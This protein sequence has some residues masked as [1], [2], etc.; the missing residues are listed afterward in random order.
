[1]IAICDKEQLGGIETIEDIGFG[2]VRPSIKIIHASIDT[3]FK[4]LNQS[5]SSYSDR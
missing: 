3:S 5:F 1:M 2:P 4:N